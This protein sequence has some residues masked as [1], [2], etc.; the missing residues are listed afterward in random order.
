[1][2]SLS[3]SQTIMQPIG[4]NVLP[5]TT[6]LDGLTLTPTIIDIVKAP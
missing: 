2:Y 1:M 4:S 3:L 6:A 5:A